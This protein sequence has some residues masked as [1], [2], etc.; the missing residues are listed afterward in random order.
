MDTQPFVDL[1]GYTTLGVGGPAR[2]FVEAKTEA[3][4]IEA[5]R[6]ADASSTPLLVLGG[7]S[8]L[9]VSDEGFDGRVVR[10]ANGG[11]VIHVEGD[12]V[13]VRVHAGESWDELVDMTIAEGCSG[14]ECMSGIP[15]MTGG[16]VVQNIGAY[17]E[18][19][20]RGVETVYVWDRVA[21]SRLDLDNEACRFEYRNS[22]FKHTETHVVLGVTLRLQRSRLSIPIT[23][24]ELA[25]KLDIEVGQR[26]PLA[27][28]RAAVLE[29]RS[30]K[31]MVVDPADP[32]SRSA[33]SFFTNPVL[34]PHEFETLCT[35]THTT[36]PSWPAGE[37]RVKVSAAWLIG[38]AGY[39]KGFALGNARI[40]RKH[41]LAL[42]NGGDAKAQE[43]VALARRVRDDVKTHLGVWLEPEPVF[44]GLSV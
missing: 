11:A 23:Y 21:K 2:E 32:E 6:E 39:E 17:G 30:G 8:N 25:R 20:R 19:I 7:G 27:D 4:V 34:S 41:T 31:G 1:S 16:A 24:A 38:A 33:G 28:V 22:R 15:G 14:L 5:V 42:V 29:L 3:D 18:E 12:A 9:L 26:A 36:P 13:S 40:S 35:L 44:V 37:G 43:I 10:V